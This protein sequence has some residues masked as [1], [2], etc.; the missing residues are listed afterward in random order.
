MPYIKKEDR[1]KFG[2]A[3]IHGLACQS[4][5]ELNYVLTQ[6]CM[7]YIAKFGLVKYE[8]I[9]DVLG[10]LEGCKS[11]FV[12]RIASPHEAQKC[13]EHGDVYQSENGNSL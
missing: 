8:R 1:E 13:Q 7:G 12:R 2:N 9:N 5:G 11:E 10:A 6:V 4:T 3:Q